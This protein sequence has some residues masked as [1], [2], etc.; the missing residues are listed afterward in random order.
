[1]NPKE[2]KRY[3]NM[4]WNTYWL[5]IYCNKKINEFYDFHFDTNHP[6]FKPLLNILLKNRKDLIKIKE[7][8]EEILYLLGD[9]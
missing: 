1:M 5:E 9:E 6:S 4:A 2:A 7:A 3:S 8:E